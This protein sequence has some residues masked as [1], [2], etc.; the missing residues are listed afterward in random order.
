MT[1]VQIF[2][3]VAVVAGGQIVP[4]VI[5]FSGKKIAVSLKD[6]GLFSST[7]MVRRLR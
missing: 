7:R 1:T 4:R 6:G 2:V 5:T 3:A